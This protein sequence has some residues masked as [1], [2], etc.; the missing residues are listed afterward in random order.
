VQTNG[1]DYALWV[2]EE[3]EIRT[4][5]TSDII[6]RQPYV[7]PLFESQNASGREANKTK[8]LAFRINKCKFTG[9]D[10]SS[11]NRVL[12]LNSLDVSSEYGTTDI[13]THE[14]HID[15]GELKVPGTNITYQQQ[16]RKTSGA[17]YE[18][19]QDTGVN[20]TL[21]FSDRQ[22][23]VIRPGTANDFVLTA[24]LSS[25]NDDVSPIIDPSK[26][27]V[28]AIENDINSQQDN[29]S[30]ESAS[31][32]VGITSTELPAMRYISRQVNL[33]P[34]FESTDFTLRLEQQR[35]NTTSNI[36]AF[37]KVQ[38]DDDVANFDAKPFIKLNAATAQSQTVQGENE[39]ITVDYTLTAG[40]I[41]GAESP[42]SKFAV[43]IV[44]YD[45]PTSGN[46]PKVRN[47]TAIAHGDA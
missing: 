36:F 40:A 20:E 4:G 43:K 14:Y 19:A 15:I 21:K 42:Y 31:T 28:I 2:G 17:S 12:T 34:G 23:R 5:T 32:P 44:M 8:F 10:Q 45:D 29:V 41:T 16:T 18:S 38:G 13:N 27:S 39:F 47:M 46:V 30:F 9:K 26:M 33:E 25:D 37:L 35:P 22:K 3:G 7:G 24:T 11:G 6:S 1:S